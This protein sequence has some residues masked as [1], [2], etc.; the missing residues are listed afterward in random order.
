MGQNKPVLMHSQW[1]M[2]TIEVIAKVL[3][4]TETKG[5]SVSSFNSEA[6]FSAACFVSGKSVGWFSV[7]NKKTQLLT[8]LFK[9]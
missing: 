5:C 8:D 2:K 4:A 1:E 6:T 7:Q 3:S 9:C